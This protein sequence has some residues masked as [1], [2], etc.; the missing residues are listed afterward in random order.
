MTAVYATPPDNTNAWSGEWPQKAADFGRLLDVYLGPLVLYASRRLGNVHDA[1]DVVQEVFARAFMTR[2][3]RRGVTRVGPYLYRMTA[4]ACTDAL[5]KKSSRV[6]CVPLTEARESASSSKQTP[7]EQITAEEE[8]RRAEKLLQRLPV[9]QAEAIR[10]RIFGELDLEEIA[11]VTGR[12]MN[13]VSSRLR[14]GFR[15]LRRIVT[16]EWRS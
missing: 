3:K 4:N 7:S 2:K 1:E 5:R 9:A 16:K 6:R 10:L 14:Y 8:S 13:T 11:N 15:K 12:S